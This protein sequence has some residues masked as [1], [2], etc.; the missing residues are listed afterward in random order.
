MGYSYEFDNAVSTECYYLARSAFLKESKGDLKGAIKDLSLAIK[1]KN[2]DRS[3]DYYLFVKRGKLFIK[4]KKYKEAINDFSDFIS[5]NKEIYKYPFRENI[6]SIFLKEFCEIL[7]NANL[8]SDTK[9][10]LSYML[11]IDTQR[12]KS[13]INFLIALKYSKQNLFEKSLD[14]L[15]EIRDLDSTFFEKRYYYYLLV[16]LPK[17]M[18]PF[19]NLCWHLI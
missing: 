13:Y 5:Q 8:I 6:E 11:L 9:R 17:K 16:H 4:V 3:R 12:S 18:R 2:R 1:N 14:K 10:Y 15:L 7:L 19:L